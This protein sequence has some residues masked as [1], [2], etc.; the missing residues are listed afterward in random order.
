MCCLDLDTLRAAHAA[1]EA[2]VASWLDPARAVDRRYVVGGPAGARVL[3]EIDRIE[4]ELG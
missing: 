4:R 2:D 3:A 1:F